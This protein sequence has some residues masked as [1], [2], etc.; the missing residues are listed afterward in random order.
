MYNI[1]YLLCYSF[2]C[3]SIYDVDVYGNTENNH[4]KTY[5]ILLNRIKYCCGI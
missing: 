1:I 5:Y 3:A 4:N 2:E